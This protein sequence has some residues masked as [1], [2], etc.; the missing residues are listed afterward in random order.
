MRIYGLEVTP[1]QEAAVMERMRV[2]RRTILPAAF[3]R[4]MI[5]SVADVSYGNPT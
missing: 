4:L 3:S 1:E 2:P 5:W